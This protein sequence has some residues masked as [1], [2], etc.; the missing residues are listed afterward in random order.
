M[1]RKRWGGWGSRW[2]EK[3]EEPGREKGE[4]RGTGEVRDATSSRGWRESD[5]YG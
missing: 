1:Q 4:E 2:K 3:V 5:R